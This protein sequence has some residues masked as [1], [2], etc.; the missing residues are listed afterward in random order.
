MKKSR[1]L[2]CKTYGKDVFKSLNIYV[3][4]PGL[5]CLQRSEKRKNQNVCRFGAISAHRPLCNFRLWRAC[6]FVL[7]I[8]ARENSRKSQYLHLCDDLQP[9]RQLGCALIERHRHCC[10]I[11]TGQLYSLIWP[12]TLES[13]LVC[14]QKNRFCPFLDSRR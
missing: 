6:C 8:K 14:G 12:P 1:K 2:Q 13:R 3:K 4:K 7:F 5:D 9:A 10:P 11:G